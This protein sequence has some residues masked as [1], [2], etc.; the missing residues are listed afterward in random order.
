MYWIKWWD[1]NVGIKINFANH[2]QWFDV[3]RGGVRSTRGLGPTI[4]ARG[5]SIG[6]SIGMLPQTLIMSRLDQLPRLGAQ[7]LFFHYSYLFFLLGRH[8]GDCGTKDIQVLHYGI[9]PWSR[10]LN[11]ACINLPKNI[12]WQTHKDDLRPEAQGPLKSGAW[13]RSLH[14]PPSNAGYGYSRSVY[15]DV[16][17]SVLNIACTVVIIQ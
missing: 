16:C 12:A 8:G 4:T 7:I 10:I 17:V 5:Q 11:G 15:M 1:A 14:L 13:G 3:H 2:K 9:W 6:I